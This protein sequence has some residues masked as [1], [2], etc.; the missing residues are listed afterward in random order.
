MNILLADEPTVTFFSLPLHFAQTNR[1]LHYPDWIHYSINP[2]EPS[3]D[4]KSLYTND[5]E[6]LAEL[7]TTEHTN[8][9][10]VAKRQEYFIMDLLKQY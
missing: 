10:P 2:S 6:V 4:S 8:N 3:N 5:W 7:L 1:S 9:H